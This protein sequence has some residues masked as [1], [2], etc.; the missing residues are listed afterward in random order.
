MLYSLQENNIDS[1]TSA[2]FAL[3]QQQRL[4]AAKRKEEGTKWETTFFTPEKVGGG[5]DKWHYKS[6]LKDRINACS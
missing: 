1:A 2:K 3:E 5:H 6:P 4:D